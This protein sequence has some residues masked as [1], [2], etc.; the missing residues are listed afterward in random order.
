MTARLRSRRSTWRSRRNTAATNAAIAAAAEHLDALKRTQTTEPFAKEIAPPPPPTGPKLQS[1]RSCGPPRPRPAK[2]LNRPVVIFSDNVPIEEEVSLKAEAQDRGLPGGPIAHCYYRGPTG[3]CECGATV[4][5]A[6]SVW[7]RHSG[8][9]QPHRPRR[10]RHSDNWRRAATLVRGWRQNDTH[11]NRCLERDLSTR[12]RGSFR[13][14]DPQG[15]VSSG[16]RESSKT[17]TVP[18]YGG[19][20]NY[21]TPEQ[22]TP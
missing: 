1:S 4:M 21:R 2:R 14:A 22:V 5:S 15:M 10:R 18:N 17:F 16:A 12:H 9:N 6:S 7:A 19:A 13:A 20:M 8:S 11:S 3:F